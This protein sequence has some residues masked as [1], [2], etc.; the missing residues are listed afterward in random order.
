MIDHGHWW[1]VLTKQMNWEQGLK[2]FQVK[3]EEVIMKEFQK[4]QDMEGFEPKHWND[5]TNKERYI[6][7]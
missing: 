1:I 7:M 3:A 2:A 5:L 4:V 6:A